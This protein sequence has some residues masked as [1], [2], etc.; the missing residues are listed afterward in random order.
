M[1]QKALLLMYVVILVCIYSSV[2]WRTKDIDFPSC[3]D[4]FEFDYYDI[5]YNES[6]HMEVSITLLF[7][8][9]SVWLILGL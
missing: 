1:L 8:T 3:L 7:V 9:L 5:V 6:I 2:S 4:H